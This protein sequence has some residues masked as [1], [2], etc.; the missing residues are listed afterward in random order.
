M[1]VKDF[2][3]KNRLDRLKEIDKVAYLAF[4][5]QKTNKVNCFN[6]EHIVSIMINNALC[7]PNVP[8][9]RKNIR[10]DKRF[11]VAS[12][13]M[14]SLRQSAYLDIETNCIYEDYD[15]V[16]SNSEFI[17]E[18]LFAKTPEYMIKLI[19]QINSSYK[20]NLFDAAAVLIR[21]VFENLLIKS[22]EK[23]GISDVIKNKDGN[24]LMLEG[25]ITDA[26]SNTTLNLS[27][28]KGDLRIVKDVGNFAAHR[29]NYNTNINDLNK[30]KEKYRLI[31]EE[32]LYKSGLK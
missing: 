3:T 27:R 22:Y 8:R 28:C 31:V 30:I 24:Y 7:N 13:N 23:L 20:H 6:V 17:D 25:I 26:V 29:M 2:C 21:R 11:M 32:L 4:Y 1:N 15:S 5:V 16:E 19:K 12:G 14:Y 18:S 9:L 10:A